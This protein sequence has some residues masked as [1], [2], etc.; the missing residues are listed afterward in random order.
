[1]F[2]CDLKPES[3][4]MQ[5]DGSTHLES[6]I[7]AERISFEIIRLGTR[8]QFIGTESMKD[9]QFHRIHPEEKGRNF[10]CVNVVS[11]NIF[12]TTHYTKLDF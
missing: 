11:E 7:S 12:C 8:Q 1:M 4:G 6:W 2:E 10:A 5:C 3:N 9:G